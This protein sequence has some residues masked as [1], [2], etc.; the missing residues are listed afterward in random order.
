MTDELEFR[1]TVE[2]WRELVR[3]VNRRDET[4]ADQAAVIGRVRAAIAEWRADG[5]SAQWAIV[6]VEQILAA[7]PE[8]DTDDTNV[9]DQRKGRR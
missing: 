1:A 4:I 9:V 7:A 3:D 2:Q 6:H 5:R 8:L